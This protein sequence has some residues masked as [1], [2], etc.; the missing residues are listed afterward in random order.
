MRPPLRKAPGAAGAVPRPVKEFRNVSPAPLLQSRI[1]GKDLGGGERFDNV[2]P[3]TGEVICEVAAADRAI[4]NEAVAAAKA[5]QLEWIAIPAAERGRVLYRVAA[6]LRERKMELAR[7]EV[8]DTGKPIQEAPEAD[9]GSAADCFE[10][11]AGLT[12]VIHGEHIPFGENAFAYTRREPLGVCAGIGAWNYPIQ[13]A[14]WKAAPALAAGNAM[15]FKPSVLTPV[16]AVELAKIVEEAGAPAGLF[17]VVLGK[18]AI[19][20]AMADHPAIAKISLTGSVP[21]GK[22]VMAAAAGTL[23]HVTM[24]LG[25]KSALIVFDDA[26]IEDSVSA[27][28]LGNFFTQGEICSNGTRVFVQS[29]MRDAFVERLVARP[30][31]IRLGDPLDPATQMGPLIAADQLE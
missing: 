18:G 28:I 4:V 29:G 24:E 17:S 9:I 26:D 12:Q 13:I 21:T 16:T 7:L 30:R 1:A 15:I 10:F 6:R 14:S 19:G 27:A 25:G 23:K 3:A 2:N 8:R 31:A 11:F 5:A 22:R 20:A